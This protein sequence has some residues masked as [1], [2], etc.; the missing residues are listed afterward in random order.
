MVVPV[1][2]GKSLSP[3]FTITKLR[4]LRL[5]SIMQPQRDL[6]FSFSS[7]PWSVTG[8]SPT[9]YQADLAVS[10][11]MLLHEETLF[12]ILIINLDDIVFPLFTQTTSTNFCGHTLLIKVRKFAFIIHF[13]EFL[14]AIVWEGDVLL[15]F[16]EADGF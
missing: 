7:P 13:S 16:E 6:S 2:P 4:M 15:Y 12:V 14:A 11:G 8:V 10:Q 3:F 5:T 1:S 9:Q